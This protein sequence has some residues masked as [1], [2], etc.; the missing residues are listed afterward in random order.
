MSEK[1]LV[2]LSLAKAILKL[3]HSPQSRAAVGQVSRELAES[4]SIE[5]VVKQTF[6]VYSGLPEVS[7]LFPVT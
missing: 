3:A 1:P 6:K 5:S 7:Q 2:V 4:C